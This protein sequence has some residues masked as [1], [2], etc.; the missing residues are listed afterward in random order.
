MNNWKNDDGSWNRSQIMSCGHE[1]AGQMDDDRPY[2]D[3]LSI[4]MKRAWQEAKEAAGEVE[5][6]VVVNVPGAAWEMEDEEQQ[7]GSTSREVARYVG[8]RDPAGGMAAVSSRDEAAGLLRRSGVFAAYREDNEYWE[9]EVNWRGWDLMNRE[10]ETHRQA[11]DFCRSTAWPLAEER[12]RLDTVA[13]LRTENT[14]MREFK[15]YRREAGEDKTDDTADSFEP[16]RAKNEH[17][18]V[19]VD[20]SDGRKEVVHVDL[21]ERHGLPGAIRDLRESGIW[22]EDLEV[23]V[24]KLSYWAEEA[25]FQD[26]DL[27]EPGESLFEVMERWPGYL[28]LWEDVEVEYVSSK[29]EEPS[30]QDGP[31]APKTPGDRAAAPPP[32]P[33]G[34][35]ARGEEPPE[36]AE[37]ATPP[38]WDER[39]SRKSPDPTPPPGR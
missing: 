27:P 23:W 5:P 7:Q 39:S 29:E 14:A 16:P 32:P 4:G 11:A 26:K 22:R 35:P 38:G 3:R 18:F 8:V 34:N 9:V 2:S 37:P 12:D 13:H 31:R 33:K 10:F 20:A 25:G 19:F 28:D 1:I 21:Y 17:D 15:K 6:D 24:R 36:P 30:R